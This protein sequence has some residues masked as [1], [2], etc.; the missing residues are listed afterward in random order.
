MGVVEFVSPYNGHKEK[1]ILVAVSSPDGKY[2]YG[3]V[4]NWK[5]EMMK[6]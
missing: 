6:E 3:I 1:K 2:E 5:N 4:K